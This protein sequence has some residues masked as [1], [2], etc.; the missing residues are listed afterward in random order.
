VGG[1]S[2]TATWLEASLDQG[3]T[4][5]LSESKGAQPR[6]LVSPGR[7]PGIPTLMVPT[8]DLAEKRGMGNVSQP[9]LELRPRDVFTFGEPSRIRFQVQEILRSVASGFFEGRDP[10]CSVPS[11]LT[12]IGGVVL[13]VTMV[14]LGLLGVTGVLLL[15][16]FH[17]AFG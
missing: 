5:I 8:T 2:A 17:A 7:L 10:S 13:A 16:A 6:T 12:K 11:T 3:P 1:S 15:W 9:G 14:V 4:T